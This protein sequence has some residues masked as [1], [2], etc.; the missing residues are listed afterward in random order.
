MMVVGWVGFGLVVVAVTIGCVGNLLGNIN[1]FNLL[2]IN[3]ILMS[4]IEK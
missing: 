3:I 2:C 4:R 1:Y